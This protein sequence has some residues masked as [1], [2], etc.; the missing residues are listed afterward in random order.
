MSPGIWQP[1]EVSSSS[2]P[3]SYYS[4]RAI[5]PYAK[6][7]YIRDIQEANNR[8]GLLRGPVGFDLEWKPTFIKNTPENPVALVQL[9]NEEVVLLIQVSAMQEFPVKLREFLESQD[10][11]K[12]GVGIQNDAKKLF[13]DWHVSMGNCVDLALLARSADND[14]WRGNYTD[15]IGLDRLTEAYE[16]LLLPKGST[17]LS[18]WESVLRDGQQEYASN[19][20]H[21]AFVVYARLMKMA[22]SMEVPPKPV[23]YTFNAVNGSLCGPSGMPWSPFNPNYDPSPLPS[24]EVLKSARTCSASGFWTAVCYFLVAFLIYSLVSF[25]SA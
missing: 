8:V 5:H 15:S 2:P 14:R 1:S 21:A 12:T 19:D 3:K 17:R 9:A 23:Y 11:V 22:K 18:N 13:N 16:G 24:P 10:S 6:L 4:W 7:H 25:V 20:A